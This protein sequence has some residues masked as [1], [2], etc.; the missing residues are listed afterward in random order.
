MENAVCW[1]RKKIITRTNIWERISES[2][3]VSLYKQED[4]LK[5]PHLVSLSLS[6][7]SSTSVPFILS[8][9]FSLRYLFFC[10][11]RRS[12]LTNNPPYFCV[13]VCI[14]EPAFLPQGCGTHPV[15]FS[16]LFFRMLT[17]SG[18]KI[19]DVP[20]IRNTSASPGL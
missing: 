1:R 4:T 18:L 12:L 2:V 19:S 16:R 9:S 14:R 13:C 10:S 3:C 5:S 11:I 8:L 15:T 17:S 7:W 20:I 6:P